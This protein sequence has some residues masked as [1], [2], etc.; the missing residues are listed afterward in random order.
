MM[1]SEDFIPYT[2]N[3]SLKME[4]ISLSYARG[5]FS[6][7]I[8]LPYQN[9]TLMNLTHHLTPEDLKLVFDVRHS[10]V[11]YKIPRMKFS[12]SKS[13]KEPLS[14]LGIGDIFNE[15]N[16]NNM[17]VASIPLKVSDVTH[18]TK[19]D[20]DESGTI[21]AAVTAIQ[22]IPTSGQIFIGTPIQFVVNRPFMLLIHH[23][24]TKQIL[25]TATVHDPLKA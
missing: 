19:I 15:V 12:W 24:P 1:N 10:Y 9:Q 3:P 21:A 11:D 6:M 17:V 14:I 4:S 5:N 2:N 22:M 13:L 18:A 20:V 7:T 23:L 16:L 8:I 25:F